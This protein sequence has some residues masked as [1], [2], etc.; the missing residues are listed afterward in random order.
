MRVCSNPTT[1]VLYKKARGTQR[2]RHVRK[3]VDIGVV[4]HKS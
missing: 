1:G 2:G 4:L 3:E